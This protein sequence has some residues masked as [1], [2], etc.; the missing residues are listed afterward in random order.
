MVPI[1]ALLLGGWL[2]YR[3]FTAQGPVAHVRF[4]TADG[5]D[6]GK[7]EVRCRSVRVGVVKDVKLADDL[8]SVLVMLELESGFDR[9]C[10]EPGRVSGWSGRG[11]PPPTFPDS[12]P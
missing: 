9:T 6:A 5:I 8:K 7:T 1:L 4:E 11:F 12:A 10:C 2:I 3:N